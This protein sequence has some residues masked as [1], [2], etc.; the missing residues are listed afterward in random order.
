MIYKYLMTNGSSVDIISNKPLSLDQLQGLVGGLIEYAGS[1]IIDMGG[2][3]IVACCNE[4]G[5][6]MNLPIN[7]QIKTKTDYQ[8]HGNVILGCDEEGADGVMEFVGLSEQKVV[9]YGVVK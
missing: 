3:S 5:M 6:V 4:E 1:R 2:D 7:E 9:P 8:I